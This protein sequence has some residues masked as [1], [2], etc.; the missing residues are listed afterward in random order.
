MIRQ[1]LLF[2]I[3]SAIISLLLACI[4]F[5][6]VEFYKIKGESVS[7]LSSQ[8]DMLAYNLQPTL[9]FDDKDAA[10]KTLLSLKDD[11]SINRAVLYQ[12]N[13]QIFAMYWGHARKYDLR[14]RKD[15]IYENKMIGRLEIESIYLGINEKYRAYFLISLLI[16]IISIPASFIFSQPIR[17]QVSLGVVQLQQQSDRLRLLAD[18]VVSTEQKERRRIAAIIH[19]HLQ[20]FLVAAKLQL[21]MAVREMNKEQYEKA[22]LS[23]K[24]VD[25]YI[26]DTTHAARTLT[27]ELRPPVLYEDGLPAAFEWLANKFKENHNMD[28]VLDVGQIPTSLSDTLKIMVFESVKELL[29]NVVKYAH[30]QSAE[31]T[32]K[33]EHGI[34]TALVRDKGAGFDVQRT[35]KLSMDKGFGLFSIRERLKLINGTVKI[36]SQSGQGTQV[37]INIPVTIEEKQGPREAVLPQEEKED[38]KQKQGRKKITILLADDHKIVREGI[39][40]ILNENSGFNVVAQAEDGIDAIEKV[41]LFHPNVVIMDIN[42]PRLNGIE[43]TRAIKKE[44]PDIDIIGLSVQDEK[45]IVVSMQKAGAVTLL[46]KAG[47]PQEL[48]KAIM[49][50]MP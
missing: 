31:L 26:D 48:I 50:C 38:Y 28:I 22:A 2:G 45:D 3:V 6:I 41:K 8:I 42:M 9:L 46:N 34:L 12:A 11:P 5:G 37:Q 13:G 19:D 36:T 10:N 33:Y 29:L 30:V 40:N 47:D 43:A 24:R 27:V 20:Q 15:I 14:L 49:G 4:G 35:E 16:I 25:K 17:D 44:Y 23:L 18:Q 32:L 7:R 1:I 39:A 21:G